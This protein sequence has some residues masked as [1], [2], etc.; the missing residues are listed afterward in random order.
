MH[1]QM[2]A[3]FIY[4]FHFLLWNS[5]THNSSTVGM[6]SLDPGISLLDSDMDLIPFSDGG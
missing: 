2:K 5:Q 1:L 6:H 3:S 4:C